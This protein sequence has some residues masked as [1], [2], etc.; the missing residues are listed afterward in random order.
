MSLASYWPFQRPTGYFLRAATVNTELAE[1]QQT[2]IEHGKYWISR[3]SMQVQVFLKI[4]FTAFIF[5]TIHGGIRFTPYESFLKQHT[6]KQSNFFNENHVKKERKSETATV[7]SHGIVCTDLHL[8]SSN[9]NDR[10]RCFKS[11]SGSSPRLWTTPGVLWRPWSS[12]RCPTILI[13]KYTALPKYTAEEAASKNKQTA[14]NC[15]L[16][17]S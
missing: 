17:A 7:T 12:P 10:Y 2:E 11:V 8:H 5:I 3:G 9:Y 16:Q 13:K 4:R 1:Q 14:S 6:A 15:P